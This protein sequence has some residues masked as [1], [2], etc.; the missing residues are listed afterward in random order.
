MNASP[1]PVQQAIANANGLAQNGEIASAFER[2]TSALENWPK[3][4]ALHLAI[5]K[6]ALISGDTEAAQ[7]SLQ[8][9]QK[10]GAPAKRLTRLQLNI[11]IEQADWPQV[12]ALARQQIDMGIA[13][14]GKLFERIILAHRELGLLAE[15]EEITKM[16]SDLWPEQ[17]RFRMSYY[18]ALCANRALTDLPALFERN[19]FNGNGHPSE[20][21]AITMYMRDNGTLPMSII[22]LLQRA[23]EAWPEHPDV[24][25]VWDEVYRLGYLGEA[26]AVVE[27]PDGLPDQSI[28]F[29]FDAYSMQL[30]SRG[31]TR[32]PS[33]L[34]K[35]QRAIEMDFVGKTLKRPIL[36]DDAAAPV[37]ISP[38]GRTGK[39][40][41]VFGGLR[42]GIGFPPCLF[43]MY[44]A[45]QDATTVVFRDT[46]RDMF[47][48]GAAPTGDTYLQFVQGAAKLLSAIPGHRQLY[49]IGISGGGFGALNI[50]ADLKAQ[51]VLLYAAATNASKAF[52]SEIGDVR[53]ASLQQKLQRIEPADLVTPKTRIDAAGH[54]PKIS[55]YY[56]EGR[57][58]D[59]Q[60]ASDLLTLPN[61]KV[62]M[63]K[64]CST[65]IPFDHLIL[66]G[67]FSDQ[68]E[69]FL[70]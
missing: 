69:R 1:S 32:S 41:F 8:T 42:G 11:A 55:A 28:D 14:G 26:A 70:N 57:A 20:I 23:H 49:V 58:I 65:H 25:R 17:V 40:V 39:T 45:E 51:G 63:I 12:I 10:L 47:L 36:R 19:I 48:T 31:N 52:L 29:L 46:H 60:H 13:P 7:A 30:A 27:V 9:A 5:G 54:K 15:E 53:A 59:K 16:A 56:P 2:L 67:R 44:F 4:I 3:N 21:V 64:E 34:A 35:L 33:A 62:Q 43:D 6:T 38:A 18:Q 24:T 50:A 66:E 22:Q 37:L 61:T 68:L